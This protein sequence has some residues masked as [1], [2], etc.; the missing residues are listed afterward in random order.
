MYIKLLTSL[1]GIFLVA[2]FVVMFSTVPQSTAFNDVDMSPLLH[3]AGF[4]IGDCDIKEKYNH[5]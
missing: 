2:V 4:M 3:K 5:I 1:T